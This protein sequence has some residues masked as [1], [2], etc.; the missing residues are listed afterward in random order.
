MG[1]LDG[2]IDEEDGDSIGLL[3]WTGLQEGCDGCGQ[4]AWK[5]R[6]RKRQQSSRR[7]ESKASWE[8]WLSTRA[9]DVGK[10]CRRFEV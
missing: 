7:I 1:E 8:T 2:E 4:I 3:R 6:L 9:L 5:R 10:G